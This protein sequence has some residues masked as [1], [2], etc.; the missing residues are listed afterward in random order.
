MDPVPRPVRPFR[1][2]P[3][4]PA[5]TRDLALVVPAAVTAGAVAGAVRDTGAGLLESLDV[6]DEYRGEKV[7]PGQRGVTLRL[8]FR[9]RDRTLR[10]SEVEAVMQRIIIQL[11]QTLD[12][13]VRT[14]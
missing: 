12:V 11:G 13:T 1:S 4:T 10:D 14:A 9:R 8:V 3:A 2:L 6:I 5:A 7:P